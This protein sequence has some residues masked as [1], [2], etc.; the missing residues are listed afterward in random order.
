[1]IYYFEQK[2]FLLCPEAC[3]NFPES[4]LSNIK[5]SSMALIVEGKL[6]RSIRKQSSLQTEQ[7]TYMWII[8]ADI[9]SVLWSGARLRF[10]IIFETTL[11]F[12][13]V[14]SAINIQRGFVTES[15]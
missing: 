13:E 15:F 1:M 4:W 14:S 8:L 11:G 6:N 12:A 9:A 2:I 5:E 3:G 7:I 10:W